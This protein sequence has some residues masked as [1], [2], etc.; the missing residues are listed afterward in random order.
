[1]GRLCQLG[2][3]QQLKPVK[4]Y[5]QQEEVAHLVQDHDM[6]DQ[7]DLFMLIFVPTQMLTV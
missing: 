4:P 1:M 3:Q 7:V 5:Q 2:L 6:E